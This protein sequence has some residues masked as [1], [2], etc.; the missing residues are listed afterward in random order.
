V[1]RLATSAA[2]AI[3]I[4]LVL[5]MT[6]TAQA[7]NTRVVVA[8]PEGDPIATRLRKELTAMGFEPLRVDDAAGCERGA[9][10]AWVD[11]MKAAGAAC[12]D[13]TTAS[14]WVVSP[15]GL[16]KADVV[17]ARDGEDH[18]P[19]VVAVRAAEIAR[20]SLE[21]P[22]GE[23][24]SAAKS[25]AA[26]PVPP[27][28]PPSP[29]PTWTTDGPSDADTAVLLGRKK[30]ARAPA[31]RTPA[32][33]L[34]TG[35]SALMGAD[36]T[37]PALDSEIELRIVRTLALSARAALTFNGATVSTSRNA[38]RVAPSIFGIGPVVPLSAT[39]S[40]L[41][42]RLGG[43]VGVAWLRSSA[44]VPAFTSFDSSGTSPTATDSI[45]S[46]IAY[47]TAAVSMRVGGPFRLAF[48]GL[49]GTSA[50]RMV[51]R[52]EGEH[53]AY[54]GQPFGSLAMRGE[55]LFR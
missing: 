29:P 34:S 47:L 43:G 16:R 25:P 1:R 33:T 24:A 6:S 53:I 8:G 55:L 36:V 45:V 4:A 21:L 9:I 51:V 48:E 7:G 18:A 31:P 38:I 13:G 12:S 39:D 14:V 2:I 17:T 20:A 54:W 46:P 26:A 11:E 44:L 5:T 32:F 37:A 30:P 49:L 23:P 41:I 3:T 50:H 19:D 27:S 22:S 10:A 40:F 35:V 42:P 28:S 52:S 15:S